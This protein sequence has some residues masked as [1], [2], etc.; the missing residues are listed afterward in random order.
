L[1][2]LAAVFKKFVQLSALWVRARVLASDISD[3]VFT[4]EGISSS[5][6]K[7]IVHFSLEGHGSIPPT[8][9]L[10]LS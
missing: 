6:R 4:R 1:Y 8:S 2:I 9:S 5:F 10:V 7:D 3:T